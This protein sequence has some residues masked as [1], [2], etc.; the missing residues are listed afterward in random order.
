MY[1]RTGLAQ[2]KLDISLKMGGMFGLAQTPDIKSNKP[3]EVGGAVI[4]IAFNREISNKYETYLEPQ[5]VVD[6]ESQAVIKKGLGVG[7]GWHIWGGSSQ[8]TVSSHVGAITESNSKA[9][10]LVTRG[11]AYNYTARAQ[12]K[13]GPNL[14]GDLI[15]VMG[16]M[17]YR[18]KLFKH[19]LG[20]QLLVSILAFPTSVDDLRT[21]LT[22]INFYWRMML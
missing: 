12:Q 18:Q 22:E 15:E 6:A 3:I 13:G 5:V 8:K 20:M 14:K 9:L 16:G 10:T 11:G 21:D 19:D 2:E 4:A 7:W 17:Q 1:S